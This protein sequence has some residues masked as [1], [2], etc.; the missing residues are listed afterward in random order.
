M[1]KW[2]LYVSKYCKLA[3]RYLHCKNDGTGISKRPKPFQ[4]LISPTYL[5]SSLFHNTYFFDDNSRE[6]RKTKSKVLPTLHSYGVSMGYSRYYKTPHTP[7]RSLPT[8]FLFP[9]RDV[10]LS[11]YN[12]HSTRDLSYFSIIFFHIFRSPTGSSHTSSLTTRCA[13]TGSASMPP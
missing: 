9:R 11:G 5:H 4:S 3:M 2:Q 12:V 13:S 8:H 10:H 6:R 1:I 7:L